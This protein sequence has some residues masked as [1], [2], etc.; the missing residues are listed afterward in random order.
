[1][2]ISGKVD[3]TVQQKSEPVTQATNSAHI[4]T[5]SQGSPF[6]T[7]MNLPISHPPE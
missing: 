3:V 4:P 7:H 6:G 1:M 2:F 5:F